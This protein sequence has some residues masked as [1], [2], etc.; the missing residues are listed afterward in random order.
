MKKRLLLLLF[1]IFCFVGG[2]PVSAQTGPGGVGTNNG[3]S[4]LRLWLRGGEA[5]LNG[6]NVSQWSD[7]SGANNHFTNATA[8]EQP[9][10]IAN[11][12]NG[13]PVLRFTNSGTT[14]N[15]L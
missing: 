14:R 13:F 7:Q 9:A 6:G 11:A 2:G 10:H 4:A 3:S 15:Q 1:S 5:L 8:A 12:M